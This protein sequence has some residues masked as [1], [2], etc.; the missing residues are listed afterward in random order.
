MLFACR[1]FKVRTA[2]V[3]SGV[4]L[5]HGAGVVQSVVDQTAGWTSEES[6][7]D[8]LHGH[9]ISLQFHSVHTTQ[10]SAAWQPQGDAK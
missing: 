3:F 5:K 9:K 7:F 8:S 2:K 1:V 4:F 10:P 6:W